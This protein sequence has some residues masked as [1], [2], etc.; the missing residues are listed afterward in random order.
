ME[1]ELSGFKRLFSRFLHDATSSVEWEKIEKLPEGAV[2]DQIILQSLSLLTTHIRSAIMHP[3][4]VL[5]WKQS[6]A[7]I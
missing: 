6:G 7:W 3:C 2:K 1:R 4:K 5:P